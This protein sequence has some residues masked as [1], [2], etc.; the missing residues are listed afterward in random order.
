L[1]IEK[2]LAP[3]TE[4][5]PAAWGGDVRLA[6]ALV[7]VALIVLLVVMVLAR[8]LGHTPRDVAPE[9]V[10]A[11]APAP[12]GAA[13]PVTASAPAPALPALGPDLDPEEWVSGNVIYIDR[14]RAVGFIRCD[15]VKSPVRFDVPALKAGATRGPRIGDKVRFRGRHGAR[16]RPVAEEV[17]RAS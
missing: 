8:L 7:G 4:L 13:R 3:V 17:E 2:L 12:K 6:A 11:S 15:R 1:D 16:R 14:Y 9:G 5:L 10:L